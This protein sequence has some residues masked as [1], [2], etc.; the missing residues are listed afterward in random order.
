MSLKKRNVPFK[1]L[2]ENGNK[3]GK[4]IYGIE[5]YRP[6][7]AEWA[8]AQIIVLVANENEQMDIRLRIAEADSF[9]FC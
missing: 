9:Y 5:V 6:I 3:I 7:P 1:W 8:E 2:S 4:S